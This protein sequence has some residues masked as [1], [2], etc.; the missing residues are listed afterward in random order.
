MSVVF[1]RRFG[2]L[3]K[4]LSTPVARG[5]IVMSKI[6]QSV[7][8]SLVQSAIILGIAVLLGMDTSHFTVLGI[9]GTFVA[10][11]LD[12][13][14]VISVVHIAGFKISRLANTNSNS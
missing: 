14:G 4:A 6:L 5:T 2:F 8:R 10:I 1:D 11:F 12:G 7:G 13:N 9:A 3:N